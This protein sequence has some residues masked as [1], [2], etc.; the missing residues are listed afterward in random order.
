MKMR[1]RCIL[2]M[3]VMGPGLLTAMADNDAGGI[4]MYMQAGG[5]YGYVMA[6]VVLISI[7]CLAVCQELS[8]RAFRA[9]RDWRRSF[10]NDTV[11]GGAFLPSGYCWWPMSVR[12]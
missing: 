9:G 5:E 1:A 12:R 3:A 8:E 10:A 4:A 2:L 6:V 7:I 11:S